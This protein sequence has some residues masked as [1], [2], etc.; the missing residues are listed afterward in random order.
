M[1]PVEKGMGVPILDPRL[2]WHLSEAFIPF[3]EL[4][5]G[6]CGSGTGPLLYC[7]V[8]QGCEC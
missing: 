3:A 5:P 4:R 8:V 1:G 6:Y 2:L 7:A